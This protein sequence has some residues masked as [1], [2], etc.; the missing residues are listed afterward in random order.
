MNLVDC[1]AVRRPLLVLLIAAVA[2]TAGGVVLARSSRDEVPGR[3]IALGQAESLAAPA[4]TLTLAFP[5][6]WQGGHGTVNCDTAEDV[7]ASTDA[8]SLG[9][10]TRDI[11]TGSTCAAELDPRALPD[12]GAYVSAAFYRLAEVGCGTSLPT[13]PPPSLL[14]MEV[15]DPPRAALAEFGAEGTYDRFEWRHAQW[16]V[17]HGFAIRLEVFLGSAA[18]LTARELADAVVRALR[19][20]PA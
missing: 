8:V 3:V 4:G 11:G 10:F 1:R 7:H 19:F 6:D 5:A 14:D 17:G 13:T 15:D 16:C 12:A 2:G 18:S 20:T 9:S